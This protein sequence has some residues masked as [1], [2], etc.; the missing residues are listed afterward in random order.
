MNVKTKDSIKQW[1]KF[2]F[3]GIIETA[4]N[5]TSTF[6]AVLKLKKE[7]E[8]KI[9]KNGNRTHLMISIMDFLYQKPILN[10][11]KIVEITKVS[12]ATAYK[13]LEELVALQII[14]EITGGKR[15][16]IF[17]FDAYIKLFN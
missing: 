2:F 14:K 1:F 15:G 4:K 16:K 9:H 6:D 8:D 7:V 11:V 10:A 3:V 12:Q 5:G 17:V 13:I